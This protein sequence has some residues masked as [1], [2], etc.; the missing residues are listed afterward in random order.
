MTVLCRLVAVAVA[1]ACIVSGG[2][3]TATAAP[4]SAWLCRPDLAQDP[5][6]SP[7]DTTDL[8][9][10]RVVTPPVGSSR[11][12]VDCFFV[13][14]TVSNQIVGNA[15]ATPDPEV[16]SIAE[17]QVARFSNACRVYAPLYRQVAVPG[18]LAQMAGPILPPELANPVERGYDDVVRAWKEYLARD[19]R[20]RAVI[21][22]GH[23][24]GTLMLRKLIREH[25]DGNQAVRARV[26]GA[27]L[28]GGNVTVAPGRTTG[29]DFDNIP[30]CTRTGQSRCVVA[31]STDFVTPALSL[32]GNSDVDLLSR[33]W[34]LRHGPAYRVACVDP[35]VIAG[36]DRPQPITVPSKPYAPGVIKLAMGIT[37]FPSAM[38]TSRS[39]W[40]QS[41]QRGTSRCSDSGG[42][43][44]LHVNVPGANGIPLVGT[45]V[46]D[47]NYG[48]DR[49]V[50]IAAAQGE[51]WRS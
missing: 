34:G 47:M 44:L 46:L 27:F 45:H 25:V 11:D 23:S 10:G 31:Y 19:N 35:A 16:R 50:A 37:T 7:M 33:L 22:I 39:T 14:P 42:Y 30:I 29:G 21:F 17:F 26:A 24:Q 49:L 48:L 6:H 32:F 40:T 8:A 12:K 15:T 38:P 36:D 18:F 20:G 28:I 51:D 1:A 13:Y 5:C 3:T 9:N 41:A 43:R 2:L 4:R